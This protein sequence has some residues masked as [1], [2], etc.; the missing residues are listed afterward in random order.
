MTTGSFTDVASKL[1][2]APVSSVA[3]TPRVNGPPGEAAV[4]R[5][6]FDTPLAVPV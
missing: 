1:P 3:D 2:A 4:A 6:I 5:P